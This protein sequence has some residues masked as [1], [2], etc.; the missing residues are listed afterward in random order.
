MLKD[1]DNIDIQSLNAVFSAFAENAGQII[2]ITSAD[3]KRQL[4]ISE[5][6]ETIFQRPRDELYK[7]AT[8]FYS[9]I[10][11]PKEINAFDKRNEILT[12][13]DYSLD[14]SG[15]VKNYFHRRSN[16]NEIRFSYS[17]CLP[18][19]KNN[20]L[21]AFAG[22]GGEISESQ[23]Q[24]ETKNNLLHI[25]NQNLIT[26][27]KTILQNEFALITQKSDNLVLTSHV[28]LPDNNTVLLTK[29]EAQCLQH[30]LQGHSAKVTGSILFL[31]QR[32][33]EEY[34]NNIRKKF[35]ARSKLELISLLTKANVVL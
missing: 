14:N 9:Y 21:V 27:L 24:E 11:D 34:L 10:E 28:D 32:T 16:N 35:K 26:D 7:D 30:L 17:I 4:Y 20:R 31:S 3:F 22:V 8:N 18:L 29:R 6:F 12:S 23:W 19:S 33:V 1:L 5:T 15:V 25:N 13:K 2:W